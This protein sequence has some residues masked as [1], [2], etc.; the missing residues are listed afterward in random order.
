VRWEDMYLVIVIVF[1]TAHVLV[2]CSD[3]TV[4]VP[5]A[6]PLPLPLPLPVLSLGATYDD[7][8]YALERQSRLVRVSRIR[9]P[10]KDAYL[11]LRGKVAVAG[12]CRKP[13]S[14]IFAHAPLSTVQMRHRQP[15]MSQRERTRA[16]TLVRRAGTAY[17]QTRL[18][19]PRRVILSPVLGGALRQQHGHA[20]L[21]YTENKRL[22]RHESS[23]HGMESKRRLLATATL[24]LKDKARRDY[25][26]S[27][28]CWF[29]SCEVL[30]PRTTR[31][32]ES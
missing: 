12:R 20:R 28:S 9:T 18:K 14:L 25:N 5:V 13:S 16:G 1:C 26:Y 17:R 30:T 2:L 22:Q 32:S 10:G 7:V 19:T 29:P 4:P 8:L 31:R 27:D 21:Q 24:E 11:R 15:T 3:L 6:V 23:G